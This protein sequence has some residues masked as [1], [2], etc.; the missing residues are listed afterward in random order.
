MKPSGIGGQAVIE[1][2]MMRNKEDYAIAIRMPDDSINVKKDK[3]LSKTE[4]YRIFRLPIIRGIVNFVEAL[5]M[6]MQILTYSASFYEDEEDEEPSRLEKAFLK[7][8]KDKAE[9][10]AMGLTVF[11]SIILAVGI[12]IILPYF[13]S[14][15]IGS[16]IK[17]T[18]LL[19]LIEG[20]IRIIIFVSYIYLISKME[21]IKRLFMY[22]GAEHK[23]INCIENG[24]ELTVDNVKEQ[25]REHKRCGT[26][27]TFIV[28]VISIIFFVFIRVET[29][30]LRVLIRLLLIPIISGVSYE[31]LKLAGRSDSLIIRVLSKPGLLLQSFTTAEPDDDMIKVA[32]ASVEEVF[33]WRTFVGTEEATETDNSGESPELADELSADFEAI[34]IDGESEDQETQNKTDPSKEKGIT[35]RFDEDDEVLQAIEKLVGVD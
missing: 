16:R 7:I 21:D 30:W 35:N 8:F 34:D 2:V 13:I 4:E 10:V 23:A 14:E 15:L 20:A 17:S 26:S 31:F 9:N 1:G 19:A 6:G 24:H 32:I 5:V 22:H 29:I 33:D 3:Y 18:T 27:F 25:S 11:A 12:F 28:M